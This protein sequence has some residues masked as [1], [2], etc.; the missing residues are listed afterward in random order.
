MILK[1]V[2]E[3]SFARGEEYYDS[4]MVES[5]VQRGNSLFA[6]VQGSEEDLYEVGLAFREGDFNATCTCPYDW[7]GYCKHVVAVLLTWI[8]DRELVS[9]RRPLED[10]LSDLTMRDLRNLILRMV[11][12]EPGLSDAIDEFCSKVASMG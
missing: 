9:V 5:V 10:L 11:E 2:T 1:K 6:R 8:Y 7:G 4:G 3:K 12:T